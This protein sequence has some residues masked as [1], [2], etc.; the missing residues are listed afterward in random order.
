MNIYYPVNEQNPIIVIT[1][2]GTNP[3][4][5]SIVLNSHMDVPAVNPKLWSHPPFAGEMDNI[6]RIYGRGAQDRKSTGIQYF[7]AVR[8]LKSRGI[9]RFKRNVHIVFVPSE[10]LNPGLGWSEFIQSNVSKAMNIGFVLDVGMASSSN[11]TFDVFYAERHK[12]H[13]EFK[14]NGESGLAS[15]LLR[16]TP[17]EKVQFLINQF[18]ALRLSELKRLES[19]SSISLGDISTINLTLLKGGAQVD[20]IPS[21][22]TLTFDIR[23]P[24]DADL[25]AFERMVSKFKL[26]AL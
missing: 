3:K 17:A 12:W 10:E 8:A 1:W 24:I 16:N 23:L 15:M 19:N 6:G 20:I 2:G 13:I 14:C 9:K 21:D 5:P 11:D 7:A 26:I 22:M 25:V 18:M 4:L